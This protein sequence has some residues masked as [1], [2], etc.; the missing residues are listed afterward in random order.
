MI[1]KKQIRVSRPTTPALRKTSYALGEK[2]SKTRP[3]KSLTTGFQ[4]A[5]GRDKVV[6]YQRAIKVGGKASIP[7]DFHFRAVWRR[8]FE[9]FV[10]NTTQ[11]VLLTSL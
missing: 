3:I 11:T 1:T 4:R 9:S 5:V 8:A 6:A 7:K 10:S 2:L